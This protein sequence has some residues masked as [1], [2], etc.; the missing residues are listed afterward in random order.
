MADRLS[1]LTQSAAFGTI[2]LVAAGGGAGASERATETVPPR[3]AAA[4]RV[5]GPLT[6]AVWHQA[7]VITGFRQRE[8]NDGAPATYDTQV[9]LAYD[10]TTL[11]VAISALDPEPAKI[12]GYR[13]R[14][15]EGSPSDWIR[16]FVDSFHDKRSALEFAVNPAGVKQDTY[17]FNDGEADDGWDAVWDV[18]VTRTGMGW[19]A[20]FRI[21]FS[22]LRFHPQENAVFG[23]AFVRQIARLR[24]TST[25]PL[26]SKKVSGYVSS[27]GD[28]KG[29]R[30]GR[31]PKRLELLPYVVGDLTRQPVEPGNSLVKRADPDVNVGLDVKY[32]VRPGLTFTGTVNPDFGQVEADPAVVNLSAF[33][34]F[35][36]E[37]RPFFVEG[38]GIFRFDTDC[39]DGACSG[40]FYS[41]RIGRAPRGEPAIPDGGYASAPAQTTILG[42]SKLTGRIGAFAIGV[43]N[44]VTSSERATIADGLRRTQQSVE[45]LSSYSV[46]R[47]RR[48]FANQSS[49]GFIVTSTNRTLDADTRFLPD[50]AYT[51]GIDFDWR[52][53]KRYA[54]Q[55]YWAGS[56]LHGDARAIADVQENTVH[57]FQRPDAAYVELDPA[58]TVLG[59]YGAQAGFSK[60]GGERVRFTTVASVK[61]PGF[62]TNDVG[63]MQRAD[64]R[65]VTNWMQ[66]R[67]DRPNK[68]LRSFRFNLNQW[69]GWNFGSDLLSSGGNVN[70]HATFQNNWATGG[71]YTVNARVFDDRATR[72][73]PGAYRNAQRS[74]WAYINTD[75][76]RRVSAGVDIFRAGDGL[77]SAARE[78]NPALT[79]RPSSFLAISGGL[80]FGINNDRSQWIEAQDGHYVF[81]RLD[82]KTVGVR[83]RVNY[84]LTPRLSVQIYAEPFVSAGDYSDFKELADGR[85]RSY[86]ARYRPYAYSANPDFNYRSFRTTNVMRWEYR[87]GSTLFVVWQ[88]GREATLDRGTF[89]IR[90]DMAGVFDAPATNVFLVKWAYWMNF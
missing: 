44:A 75:D 21:P 17:W 25:W 43:L 3:E 34:T 36:S 87:P 57:S 46:V 47:A 11:Y 23:V 80:R 59:G 61:S 41:R 35:F 10:T 40:L 62:D 37:R 67:H 73:G 56:R 13:T 8:P 66:W 63:F 2:L 14:R 24:E 15:D 90:R 20:E 55:G 32:A 64:Q 42:A 79:W 89:D 28:L 85:S 26:L 77:G 31:S 29:L 71:G 38:S 83:T 7:Q 45:P 82:Q 9:R 33:E 12:V 53:G 1:S 48:E 54:L 86:A 5:D 16:V 74:M 70:A 65:S 76:R 4:V 58:R 72:G 60:I 30:L 50:Q 69:A 49:L 18:A 6:E 81:G 27:F 19:Q 68:Y 78:V 39:N 51:G 22:Q 88:Q 84:T 52:M